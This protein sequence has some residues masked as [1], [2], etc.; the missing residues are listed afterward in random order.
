MSSPFVH[1]DWYSKVVEEINV[2]MNVNS[3]IGRNFG[4]M[5]RKFENVN[6]LRDAGIKW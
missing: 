1:S 5:V 4:V 3:S 6:D 2:K